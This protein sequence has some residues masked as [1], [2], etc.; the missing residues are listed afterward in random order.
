MSDGRGEQFYA[1]IFCAVFYFI[2]LEKKPFSENE[3]IRKV[4]KGIN[5]GYPSFGMKGICLEIDRNCVNIQKW[6]GVGNLDIKFNE[7]NLDKDRVE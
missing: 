6:I 7:I 4:E 3:A 5:N 2:I 1:R